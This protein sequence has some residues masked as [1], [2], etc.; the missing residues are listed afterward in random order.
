MTISLR[1]FQDLEI[2][3]CP[4]NSKNLEIVR[5]QNEKNCYVLAFVDP[6]GDDIDIR[7]VSDRPFGEDVDSEVFW[8]MLKF[9][10][11]TVKAA[12]ELEYDL[13]RIQSFP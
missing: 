9:G 3:F 10:A 12:V 7:F 1:R 4:E 5:W 6:T 2:R 8:A 13:S 11:A